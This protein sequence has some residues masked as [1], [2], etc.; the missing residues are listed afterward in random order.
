MEINKIYCGDCLELIKELPDNSIDASFTSPPYN[1]IRNDTYDL[2]NDVNENYLQMLSN[3]T[4]QMI[5]VTK[6][7]VIINIQMILFN[8]VDLCKWIG[9]FAEKIKGIIV[10]E[11]DN[12]QPASNPKNGTFSI[13]NAYEFFFVLSGG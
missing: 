9:K 1:R 10:W 4:E 5:R 7:N 2:F 6:N 11:K 13:T 12:P 3:I 8:K